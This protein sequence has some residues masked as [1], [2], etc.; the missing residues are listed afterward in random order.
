MIDE[1]K[2]EELAKWAAETMNGGDFYNKNYY[3]F[4]HREAWEG[5]IR[6]LIVKLEPVSESSWEGQVDRQSGAFTDQE[7]LDSQAWK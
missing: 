1:K 5:L 7:I 2:I 6:K 3:H 4:K